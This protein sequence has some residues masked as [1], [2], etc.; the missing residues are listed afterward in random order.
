MVSF[1]IS[2]ILI[3]ASVSP[4]ENFCIMCCVVICFF[5]MF[6]NVNREYLVLVLYGLLGVSA[7][8]ITWNKKRFPLQLSLCFL[9]LIT[10]VLCGFLNSLYLTLCPVSV[11]IDDAVFSQLWGCFL[12]SY[13][14]LLAVSR[15]FINSISNCEILY[16]AS[17]ASCW[18]WFTAADYIWRVPLSWKPNHLL[19]YKEKN[20]NAHKHAKYIAV[21]CKDPFRRILRRRILVIPQ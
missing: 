6:L 15:L 4:K 21:N 12:L 16:S 10:N 1:F 13:M 19:F 7:L 5:D 17:A 11:T 8:W 20:E 9:N 14:A 18:W 2:S 3:K